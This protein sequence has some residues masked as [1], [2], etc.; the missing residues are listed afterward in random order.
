M[1]APA[2][3]ST[4]D[5]GL[6]T[7]PKQDGTKDV[8]G[9]RLRAS[10]P[11][12]HPQQPHPQQHKSQRTD[13][14]PPAL[15]RLP[16][17]LS[18]SSRSPFTAFPAFQQPQRICTFSYDQDR[19][20][21]HDDRCKRYYRGPPLPAASNGSRHPASGPRGADLNYGFERF[22][23]RDESVN[24]HLDGLLDSLRHRTLA[25]PSGKARDDVDLTRQKADVVTWRGIATKLCTA[26]D[27]LQPAPGAR[28]E[29]FELNAMLVDGTLYLEE[30][31]SPAKR[32]DKAQKEADQRL[33]R[34]GYY[35]Y[36]FESWSTVEHPHNCHRPALLEHP[37]RQTASDP[38]S[39]SAPHPPGWGG[40]VN[41]NQQWCYIV[42]TRLGQNRLILGGE[43][44]C[45]HPPPPSASSSPSSSLSSGTASD[46][47]VELKTS[48]Q[49]RPGNQRDV[50]LFEAKLLKFYMQSFLLGVRTL[51]VGFRDTRGHLVTTQTFD[52]LSLPKMVRAGTP[53]DGGGG[54]GGD[55]RVR[56]KSVW[57][58]KDSVAFGERIIDWIRDVVGAET[59]R[60]C[61]GAGEGEGEGELGNGVSRTTEDAVKSYPVFRICYQAPFHELTVR[62]LQDHEV[63]SEIKEVGQAD[64]RVGFLPRSYY[65]FVVEMA[66]RRA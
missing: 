13:D 66:Q 47:L 7:E 53:L 64:Q 39:D 22:K 16:H 43:V 11:L 35:G 24:E 19:N 29:G 49:I 55:G 40:D 30:H 12:E 17:P 58:P 63:E 21:H 48:M 14:P 41:T 3:P 38:R 46:S 33:R 20:L 27:Q 28:V 5:T 57:D 51:V 60:I 31:S 10:S 6:P 59:R 56:H 25:A 54:G 36:S 26:W 37:T 45:V 23:Q 32:L 44:D 50:D 2:I 8:L 4:T 65:D 18:T 1:S 61:G 42:K 15:S 62:A 9:K 34:F 52:T